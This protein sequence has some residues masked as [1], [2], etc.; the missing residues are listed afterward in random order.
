MLFLVLALPTRHNPV[1]S[2]SRF[3][4]VCSD[5]D[6]TFSDLHSL[7]SL[8]AVIVG[9]TNTRFNRIRA[10]LLP[11]LCGYVPSEYR[12]GNRL[13]RSFQ[14]CDPHHKGHKNEL[15]IPLFSL[16][17]F[18]VTCSEIFTSSQPYSVNKIHASLQGCEP[19]DEWTGVF[20]WD[21]QC[22]VAGGPRVH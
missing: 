2:V 9:G 4:Y 16:M 15:N 20:P 21:L 3:M 17:F 18:P 1:I 12:S 8:Q 6:G 19:H 13:R 22:A 7:R 10:T 11:S 5:C 14:V